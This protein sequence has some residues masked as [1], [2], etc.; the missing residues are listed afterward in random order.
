VIGGTLGL[1]LLLTSTQANAAPLVESAPQSTPTFNNTV[2][3][4]AYRGSTV[5][6]GGNFTTA[7]SGG[8]SYARQRLAAFD[9]N[10]GALLNWKPSADAAVRALAV[11]GDAV[12]A[13]GDFATISG[14]AR[15]SLARLDATS[16]AVGAFSHDV[17]GKPLALGVGSG[18]VYVAGRF[19]GIDGATRANL[20]AFSLE[21]GA[22]DESWAPTTDDTV[23]SLAVTA[24]RVYLAG[25][26]HKVNSI[27]SALRLVAVHPATG[28]LDK[29]FL[30]KPAVVVHAVAVDANG[31]YAA[32]GGQGGRAAAY[33][34]NGTIRWTRVFD[35]DAQAI[36]VLDGIAYVGGHFDNACTTDRNGAHGVCTDGIAPRVKLA[37][38]DADGQLL[39]WAPQANGVR[40]ALVVAANEALGVVCAGGEFTTI[41]GVTQRRFALFN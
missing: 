35:G 6:V 21:S 31:V 19:T 14:V 3:A 32:L 40:G 10:T 1:A 16:G 25:S 9:A 11:A 13:A 23:E 18:K 37:A 28:A 29:G 41:G 15:D 33:S 4:V 22:L 20:A 2:Y 39:D 26:F 12:Y 8:K 5:Y 38:V 7:Y 36:A 24:D 17:A 27:S 34:L 30:P